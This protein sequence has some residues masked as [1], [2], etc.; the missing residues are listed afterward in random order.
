[1]IVPD[2]IKS[3]L[4]DNP[5]SQ[6][7]ERLGAWAGWLA[8][9]SEE[10]P[11]G[12]DVSYDDNFETV[13]SEL[14]KLSGIDVELIIRLSE[15]LLKEQ[16]KD[17]RVGAYYA[18]AK[19]RYEGLSGFSD[20]LELICGLI[21]SFD[22]DV[23]PKKPQQRYTAL[24]WLMGNRTLDILDTLEIND[25]EIFNR[26]LSSLIYLQNLCM[27]WE[28]NARP[29]FGAILEKLE[30]ASFR[31]NRETPNVSNAQKAEE[32]DSAEQHA[33][34]VPGTGE[35]QTQI[36]LPSETTAISSSKMLLDQT[37]VI[38]VFLRQQ[39]YGYWSAFKMVRAVRWGTLTSS[40]PEV[41]SKT[42]LKAPRTDVVAALQRL[43][44]EEN[45][46]DLLE[47]VEAAFLEG[48]N[49]YWL[50]LQYY[51]WKAQTALGGVYVSQTASFLADFAAFLERCSGLSGLL[52]DNGMAFAS[53]NV[54]EWLEKQVFKPS[55]VNSAQPLAQV[56]E[57]AVTTENNQYDEAV[58][59]AEA[60]GI[61]AA[62]AWLSDHPQL[63]HGK[64]LCRKLFWMAKLAD[65][66]QKTEWSLY[67]L[68]RAAEE[69]QSMAVEVWD[70]EFAFD[71]YNLQCSFLQ[72]KVK[73]KD[74]QHEKN[75]IM[76]Q[77][78]D[79]QNRLIKIDAAK[80]LATLY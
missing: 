58:V 56:M 31:F 26:T 62:M 19:L 46:L 43:D 60:S 8:P 22:S 23:W 25:K 24:S 51:A 73:R 78:S 72:A 27:G 5:S 3:V 50:D 80:A 45:W 37:R 66:Y 32:G 67:L 34:I 13:K 4:G 47:K 17:L 79:L 1:M 53:D 39:E 71:L 42:R 74:M 75:K 57:S 76:E 54:L 12:S 33:H 48:A 65:A 52:F 64:F 18:Y 59:I 35:K 61:E 40:P 29:G 36:T 7:E 14:A 44:K 15:Q 49:H 55:Y 6:A 20:G 69:M 11:A 30:Q 63:Q 2:W 16:A 70:K 41:D 10:A 28:E 9:I 38:A 77:I 68:D 21:K